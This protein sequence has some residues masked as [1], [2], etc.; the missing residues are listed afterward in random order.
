LLARLN[1]AAVLA[2]GILFGALESGAAAMQRD[3]G[4]PSVLVSVVEAGIILVL[5]A[6][7]RLRTRPRFA[8]A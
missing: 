7:E 3:A 6:L 4:V 1:P 2:T 5:V 8:G